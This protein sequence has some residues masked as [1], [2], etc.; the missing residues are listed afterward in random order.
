MYEQMQ[1]DSADIIFDGNQSKEQVLKEVGRHIKEFIRAMYPIDIGV[2]PVKY[3]KKLVPITPHI[4][5]GMPPVKP[6]WKIYPGDL[7]SDGEWHPID[8]DNLKDWI[9][10]RKSEFDYGDELRGNTFRYRRVQ[11]TG[12]YE[13]RLSSKYNMYHYN[14]P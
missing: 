10:A 2:P 1:K 8:Y 12:T 13:V 11:N 5:I 7:L 3:I 4:D 14:P 9:K 6:A